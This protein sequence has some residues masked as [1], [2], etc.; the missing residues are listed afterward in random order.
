MLITS[1]VK[2]QSWGGGESRIDVRK[3]PNRKQNA[4]NAFNASGVYGVEMKTTKCQCLDLNEKKIKINCHSNG[5]RQSAARRKNIM[6][7]ISVFRA[8]KLLLE[9][10]ELEIREHTIYR[11]RN[12]SSPRADFADRPFFFFFFI[13]G[14]LA[15]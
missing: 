13:S 11:V 15:R 12:G 7:S 6:T 8:E 14:F 3:I 4:P 10:E 5:R 9:P 2:Q 1:R